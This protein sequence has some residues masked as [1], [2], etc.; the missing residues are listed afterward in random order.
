M[1]KTRKRKP[2]DDDDDDNDNVDDDDK[3]VF[4]ILI[5]KREIKCGREM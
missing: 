2:T 5:H 1:L 4:H 3:Y